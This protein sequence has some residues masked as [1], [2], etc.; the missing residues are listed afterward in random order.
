[1]VR[2]GRVGT[3]VICLTLGMLHDFLSYLLCPPTKDSIFSTTLGKAEKE[4]N[5]GTIIAK[6]LSQLISH[7][8][9]RTTTTI[10]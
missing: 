7:N 4:V 1:M 10:S 5:Y 9:P 6:T 3:W 8:V 2:G